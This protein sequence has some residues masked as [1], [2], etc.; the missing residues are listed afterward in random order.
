MAASGDEFAISADRLKAI[1]DAVQALPDEVEN[2]IKKT[3]SETSKFASLLAKTVVG[4]A[5]A[6]DAD[7]AR[8][9][10]L[11]WSKIRRAGARRSSTAGIF[12]GLNPLDPVKDFSPGVS[13]SK[14]GRHVRGMQMTTGRGWP[15]PQG[16]FL[17]THKGGGIAAFIRKGA[18]RL[19]L[20]RVRM[21]LNQ[22]GTR[23]VEIG[24][25]PQVSAFFYQRFEANLQA[26]MNKG[27]P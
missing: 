8:R 6:L 21:L 25:W 2:A 23:A 18:S 20:K 16:S 12:F 9:R 3:V 4:E 11:A 10:V 26:A 14:W 15:L 19:P 24:V 5:L 27:E 7:A 1:G 13:Q 17:A 22:E